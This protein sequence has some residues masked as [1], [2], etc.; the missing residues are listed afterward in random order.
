[1]DNAATRSACLAMSSARY[2]ASAPN[3]VI[4]WV[5]LIRAM[6]WRRRRGR[7]SRRSCRSSR[8]RKRDNQNLIAML[9]SSFCSPLLVAAVEVSDRVLLAHHWL[10]PTHSWDS[11]FFPLL[12]TLVPGG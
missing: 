8:R 3:D 5:P 9:V 10:D 4:N 11:T 6:P 12:L 2:N 1:M 7:S